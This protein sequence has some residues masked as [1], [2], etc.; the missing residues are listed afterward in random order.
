ML[1][2]R[3]MEKVAE[4]NDRISD[5]VSTSD[6]S[7]SHTPHGSAFTEKPQRRTGYGRLLWWALPRLLWSLLVLALPV[8]FLVSVYQDAASWSSTTA[9]VITSR[10][11]SVSPYNPERQLAVIVRFISPTDGAQMAGDVAPKLLRTVY[12]GQ[13]IQVIVYHH[14]SRFAVFYAGPGGDIRQVNY[15]YD[16]DYV[17]AAALIAFGIIELVMGLYRCLQMVVATKSPIMKP[18]HVVEVSAGRWTRRIRAQNACE[19]MDLEWRVLRWQPSVIGMV[20][21]G[22]HFKCGGW[23]VIGLPG[24]GFIWPG[25]RAQPVIGTGL[26]RVLQSDADTSP[27]INAHYRLLA[28]YGQ[29]VS[30]VDRLPFIV[31]R[32]P[33]QQVQ[34]NWWWLGAPRVVVRSLVTLHIRRRLQILSNALTRAGVLVGVVDYDTTRSELYAASERCRALAATLPR[35]IWRAVAIFLVATALPVSLTIYTAFVQAAP[36]HIRLS[37]RPFLFFL[38]RADC[39]HCCTIPVYPISRV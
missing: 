26:Q 7:A 1:S 31:R 24:K 28:A 29:L 3:T 4:E 5:Q 21:V 32:P 2:I 8:G 25:S 19:G 30:E 14:G 35:P 11:I 18:V 9:T 36:I 27:V 39:Y 17:V 33:G 16:A 34:S 20:T 10:Y 37:V 22:G 12:P 15:D 38:D 13:H 6:W 23:L